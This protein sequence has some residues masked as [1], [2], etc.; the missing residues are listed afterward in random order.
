[1][2][3]DTFTLKN[4]RAFPEISAQL[5]PDF[6][7]IIGVNGTGKTSIL[8]GL[9]I[10]VGSLFLDMDKVADR[11][12]TPH[13]KA[14]DVRLSNL[15]KQY[16]VEVVSKGKVLEHEIKWSRELEKEGG[17]TKTIN[18]RQIKECSSEIQQLVRDGNQATAIPLISYYSTERY[19]REKYDTGVEPE[20]SRLRGYYN[21]MDLLTNLQFF[22]NLFRT[23]AF[24][25]AQEGKPSAM[26]EAVRS[27]VET[28]INTCER[29]W[30]DI[31]ADKLLV[32][33]KNGET[34]PLEMLSDG[35]RSMASMVMEIAFRCYLLNPW[36]GNRAALDTPGIILIDE[37][38]LHI[39]PSWQRKIV[40][41]LKKAFPSIQFVATT[42][43][44]IVVSSMSNGNIY[45]LKDYKLYTF[46]PQFGRDANAVLVE[47]GVSE[48]QPEVENKLKRYF[49]L[50]ENEKGRQD[51]ALSLRKELESILGQGNH[52][53][54]LQRADAMLSFFES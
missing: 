42:H 34:L 9:R 30:H 20:G 53:P 14:E 25:E 51:E 21:A 39:H 3:I 26:I 1:M 33:L 36:L 10:A 2:R 29:L 49:L 32:K 12:Y 13:I 40:G 35:I 22:R 19:K 16:P 5:H 47:M 46:P 48:R 54:D 15:E 27:A 50:I 24:A 44:P 8:E 28:C 6:N 41:D 43:S 45:A 4:F 23:E 38:D 11:I 31:R 37:I 52:A 18:A 7:L 17:R